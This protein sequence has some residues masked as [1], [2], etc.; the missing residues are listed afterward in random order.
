[1]LNLALNIID[2]GKFLHTRLVLLIPAMCFEP[3][4]YTQNSSISSTLLQTGKSGIMKYYTLL[5]S[6]IKCGYGDDLR[7]ARLCC[8]DI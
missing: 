5:S 6:V 8:M 7:F 2:L 1:M 4:G 3:K